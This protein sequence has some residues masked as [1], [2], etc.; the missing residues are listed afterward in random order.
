[1]DDES[2]AEDE[3]VRLFHE[4]CGLTGEVR[5]RRLAELEASEP[6]LGRSLRELL[7][8][9]EAGG[10]LPSDPGESPDFGSPPPSS[11]EVDGEA[12]RA[13]LAA[14]AAGGG[15]RYVQG[16]ELG[17]GAMGLVRRVEDRPLRRKLAM[18][19]LRGEA[20]DVRLARFLNEAR[21]LGRLDHP[22]IVSIH[23]LGVDEEGRPFFTM[24]VL[25]GGELREVFTKARASEDGWS[26]ARAVGVLERVCE[27]MAHA[28]ASGVVH[29]DLKPSN[30]MVGR[31]GEVQ[32]VDW[33]I[34]AVRGQRDARD[35]RPQADSSGAPEASPVRTLDGAVIGTPYF[36]SPEQARGESSAVD[37]RS[38][39]YALGAMLYELLAGRPPFERD[40]GSNAPYAVLARVQTQEPAPLD[41]ARAP[42]ELVAICRRAMAREREER[43]ADMSAL[44]ADLRAHLEQRVVSAH[45]TGAMAEL[46][47]W[48]QRNRLAAGALG[49]ALLALVAGAGGVAAVQAARAEAEAK[50]VGQVQ[51]E[52][53][54]VQQALAA[55]STALE[56]KSEALAQAQEEGER[57]R[58]ELAIRSST[59]KLVEELLSAS[60][61]RVA[62]GRDITAREVLD[63]AVERLDGVEDADPYVVA[64]VRRFIGSTLTSLSILPPAIEQLRQAVHELERELGRYARPVHSAKWSL[65]GAL[66]E[67]GRTEEAIAIM[68][69]LVQ[70]MEE[71]PGPETASYL[72][73]KGEL[74]AKLHS[75]GFH[76]EGG[77]LVEEAYRACKQHL[78][79]RDETTLS[80]AAKLLEVYDF[81]ERTEEAIELAEEVL[82][83]RRIGAGEPTIELYYA[84]DDLGSAL[85]ESDRQGLAEALFRE[86]YE[87]MLELLGPEHDHPYYATNNLASLCWNQRRLEEAVALYELT[88]SKRREI[89]GEDSELALKTQDRYAGA[90]LDH[91][92]D[93]RGEELLED[94]LARPMLPPDVRCNAT[95]RLGVA[96]FK[97]A[98]FETALVLL[99]EA[100]Q[101]WKDIGGT[102]SS[103]EPWLGRSAICL[104]YMGRQREAEARYL[105]LETIVPA[106]LR[107]ERLRVIRRGV[108]GGRVLQGKGIEDR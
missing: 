17:R 73:A 46:G 8:A 86:A 40:E 91:G 58:R 88:W 70:D 67:S 33:G 107:E 10:D 57:A 24:P 53:R 108:M 105:E 71:L 95:G 101:C 35:P 64:E 50:L 76:D 66:E 28:H 22:G 102:W 45:R 11:A 27:A 6:E 18:K 62:Q 37:E 82:E 1:M 59:L 69:A 49:G 25:A 60:R 15:G 61:P 48:V 16:E 65:A 99:E 84:M 54:N 5:G 85:V 26:L 79:P 38:D 43:Y 87:G 106:A 104:V 3:L 4:V 9:D 52:K 41:D 29:R 2:R 94:L 44:A 21:V 63:Q 23:E 32:V 89:L 51:E 19:T 31:F 39:V 100:D 14:I 42:E 36:M 103:R 78:P 80:M 12:L 30:V 90:L 68:R 98:D 56:A 75:A 77:A 97:R 93:G 72:G 96:H 55:E 74:G 47:K 81:Q 7:A 13:E 34:A 83:A 20:T 92:E